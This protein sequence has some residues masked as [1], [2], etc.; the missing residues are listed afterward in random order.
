MHEAIEDYLKAKGTI[1]PGL[2]GRA[3][4]TDLGTQAFSQMKEGKYQFQ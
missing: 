3:M 2:D 1:H 4:A